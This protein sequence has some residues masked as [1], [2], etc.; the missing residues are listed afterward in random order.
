MRWFIGSSLLAA[1]L[2][3]RAESQ[4]TALVIDISPE[5]TLVLDRRDSVEIEVDGHLD[6]SIWRDLPAYDEFVVLKPDTLLMPEYAT[7]VRSFYN[8]KGLYFG[9]DMEQP[10]E[11][12]ITRLSGRDRMDIERERIGVTLDTSGEGRFG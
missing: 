3:S 2:I 9:V 8:A 10:V 11:T 12:L 7:R 6:E 1:A 4:L 5:E